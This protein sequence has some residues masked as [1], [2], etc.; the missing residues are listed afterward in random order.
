MSILKAEDISHVRF[1]APDLERMQV[2]LDEFGL[3]TYIDDDRALYGR[4][5]DGSA[6]SHV[7]VKGKAAFVGLGLRADSIYD[8]ERLASAEGVPIEDFAC[9]GGGKCVRLEDPDGNLVEVVC[10]QRRD[11]P[12]PTEPEPPVN[13]ALH[14]ARKSLPVRLIEGPSR[15]QRLGHCVLNVKNFRT[16]EAW[17]KSR[18][19]FIT[20]DEIEAAPN[21]ALGAFLRCDRGDKP[22]DHHTL[23]LAQLPGKKGFLHAAF[24]VAGFNDL[25]LGHAHLKT[26]KRR[27]IWGVGRHKLGS[28]IFDYWNDP[29]GHE[30]EH[31]TDGDLF[32]ASDGSHV[33]TV[34]DLL[35][36]QWGMRN[37]IFQGRFSPSPPLVEKMLALF[38]RF[39]RWRQRGVNSGGQSE[40]GFTA[41]W[42][43]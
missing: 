18:F 4:A 39:Q 21:L 38:L 22:T 5:N 19:G 28:Q 6:F 13:S 15:V 12:S 30:L 32:T 34:S 11:S 24:E 9:P 26:T 7:T 29:W 3:Q 27:S 1:R 10:D 42:V 23:F 35:E 25:M 40:A 2:F 16:S 14:K 33:A 20:S 43:W 8:L 41:Y 17:Y 37:P 31:W 36:V